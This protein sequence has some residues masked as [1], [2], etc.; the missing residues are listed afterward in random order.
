[1]S[2]NVK[3]SIDFGLAEFCLCDGAIDLIEKHFPEC[4]QDPEKWLETLDIS[5]EGEGEKVNFVEADGLPS[6]VEFFQIGISHY[7]NVG[8]VYIFGGIL[9]GENKKG[10]L[11]THAGEIRKAGDGEQCAINAETG[12]RIERVCDFDCVEVVCIE[13]DENEDHDDE[14]DDDE[15][16]DDEGD[17]DEE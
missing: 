14:G 9:P 17:D 6:D 8:A 16:D 7:S 15:G 10:I 4:A 1:M 5:G 2:E 3:K 13:I 11:F 12:D